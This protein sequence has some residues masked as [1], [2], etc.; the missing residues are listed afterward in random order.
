MTN[1]DT[2]RTTDDPSTNLLTMADNDNY[3]AAL[4]AAVKR[5]NVKGQPAA[6]TLPGG[7]D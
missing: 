6:Y 3:A 7:V 1:T 4:A 5:S 2:T